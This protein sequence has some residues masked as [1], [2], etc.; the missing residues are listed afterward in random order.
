MVFL[1]DEFDSLGIDLDCVNCEAIIF[2]KNPAYFNGGYFDRN[3]GLSD[4][5]KNVNSNKESNK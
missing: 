4:Q 5:C 1:F 3:V 2:G